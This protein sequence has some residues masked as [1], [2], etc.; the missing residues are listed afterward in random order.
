MPRFSLVH[1]QFRACVK[2]RNWF[3]LG[4]TIVVLAFIV[5]LE[6]PPASHA[7]AQCGD[8]LADSSHNTCYEYR[9][10]DLVYG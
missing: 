1:S 9:D 6:S 2:F 10:T 8:L 5:V 4:S 7:Q 3:F